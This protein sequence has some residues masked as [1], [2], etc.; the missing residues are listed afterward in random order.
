MNLVLGTIR[1]I[2]EHEKEVIG[3]VYRLIPVNEWL[4]GGLKEVYLQNI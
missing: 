2:I 3:I 1:T 4:Y